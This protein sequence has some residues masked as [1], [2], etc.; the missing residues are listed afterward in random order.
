ML[1][2][3]I[4]VLTGLLPPLQTAI[5]SR[6]NGFVGSPLRAALISF[7]TGALILVLLVVLAFGPAGVLADLAEATR[8]PAWMWLGG[9][10]GAAIASSSIFAFPRL[11]SIETALWPLLGSVTASIGVDAAG[12]LGVDQ[13]PLSFL[14]VLGALGVLIGVSAASGALVLG[15]SDSGGPG[16]GTR[17]EHPDAERGS[18]RPL[19]G[20]AHPWPWRV[21]LLVAGAG[22]GIQGA[23][24]GALGRRIDAPFVAALISFLTGALA[25]ALV[26]G[27]QAIGSR[28]APEAER[29]A[30]GPWW[31]W[32]G[33]LLGA[34]FVT[35]ATFAVPAIGAGPA[36]VATYA[37]T[38]ASSLLIDRFGWFL[39]PR[40]S[41]APL[42]VLGVLLV[43]LGVLAVQL[44]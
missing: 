12:W 14:R 29:T 20:T 32:L 39:A 5:N 13:R 40:K 8:A 1:V 21:L 27:I 23:V 25:L 31:M 11:G 30:G 35:T 6:L 10:L 26:V 24:N 19:P 3:F 16:R 22:G 17:A 34:V 2:L 43:L 37:G 44:G 15:R 36:N 7:S 18:A 28:G 9:L 41:V 4:V 38:S 42:Q 33:G